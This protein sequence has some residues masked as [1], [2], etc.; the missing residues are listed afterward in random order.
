MSKGVRHHLRVTKKTDWVI[1][2]KQHSDLMNL[3]GQ[4]EL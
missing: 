1:F 2:F 4:Y 3:L